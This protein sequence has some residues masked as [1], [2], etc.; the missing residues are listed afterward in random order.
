[1]FKQGDLVRRK[2]FSCRSRVNNITLEIGDI[3]EVEEQSDEY[4]LKL[5]GLL[6]TFD[7]MYFELL[8]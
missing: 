2:I 5:N 6:G 3:F 7:P 4:N 8:K 1:M